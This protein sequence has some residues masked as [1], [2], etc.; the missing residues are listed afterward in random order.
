MNNN[1]MTY[2]DYVGSVE[3]S[4][5]DECLFGRILGINDLITFEGESVKELRQAFEEAVED[6]LLHCQEVGKEPQKTYSGKFLLRIDPCLHAKLAT[7][8]QIHNMS[9]NQY[10]AK[11]L[12]QV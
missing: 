1:A 11:V 10:A 4:Q 12:A 6:Y 8:A 2:K 5:D 3:Y 9:L 7:K